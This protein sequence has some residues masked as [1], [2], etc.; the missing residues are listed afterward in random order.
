MSGSNLAIENDKPTLAHRISRIA[1]RPLVRALRP[2]WHL[3]REAAKF[4]FGRGGQL[5]WVSDLRCWQATLKLPRT[6]LYVP[7]RNY[8]NLRQITQFGAD[9]KSLV[10]DW[11]NAI[12]D[13]EMLYDIGA[14]NGYEGMYTH[15]AH[16]CRVASVEM[17]VPSVEN[18]LLAFVMAERRGR[19][20]SNI[21]VLFGACDSEPSY[22][23]LKIHN[24]PIAG[25]NKNSFDDVE[26]YCRGGRGDQ[27][28][29]ATYWSPAI[30]I[31]SL[32]GELGLPV[33][34]HVKI[35]VDGFEGRVM[36][37]A[38][39]TLAARHVRQWI[40]EISPERFEEISRLMAGCGY[41]EIANHEHYPGKNDCFD[42]LYVRDDLV[43]E[44]RK[45][46][47]KSQQML[48]HRRR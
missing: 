4:R 44:A 13:C 16:G 17:F 24:L 38:T 3:A 11:L 29:F 9:S 45:T 23:K 40:I 12:D 33:P 39:Q 8:R 20:M 42:R 41:Q 26:E 47:E 5:T 43:E 48:K 28:V 19:D 6:T 7:V 1:P 22:K 34:T 15:A 27:T 10:F 37:G 30:S 18:I 21:E 35:D 25:E 46:L 36:R 32:H 14:S 2:K 31:D